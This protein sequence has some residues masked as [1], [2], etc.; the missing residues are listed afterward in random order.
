[1][2]NK[3]AN[4]KKRYALGE[5]SFLYDI[6]IMEKLFQFLEQKVKKLRKK[7]SLRNKGW[8]MMKN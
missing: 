5:I 3:Y 1:M 6:W 7:E 2:K 8:G 4:G